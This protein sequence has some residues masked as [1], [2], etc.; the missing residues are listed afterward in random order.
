MTQILV[1]ELWNI[2]DVILAM[3][4]LA[5]LR[6]HFPSSRI[7]LLSR[8]FA[9]ELLAGTGLVDEFLEAKLDW[10]DRNRGNF[11]LRLIRTIRTARVLR[12]RRFDLVFSARGHKRERI[13]LALSGA[14]QRVNLRRVKPNV[15]AQPANA[16][17][18]LNHKVAQ[19]MALLRPF[20]F[21][22]P[23]PSVAL[24]VSDVERAQAL[25]FLKAHG[26]NHSEMVI[27][28]HP[29]ASRPEKRWPLE[30]FKRLASELA[31]LPGVRVIAFAEP[32]PG[33]YGS[34][35]FEIPGVVGVDTTLRGL[36]ALIQSCD[37]LICNDSGPMHIA[38][39][40]GVPTVA[41]F[42]EGISELFGP[43]GSGHHLL[44]PRGGQYFEDG[45]QRHAIR[46]PPGI[47]YDDAWTTVRAALQ[48]VHSQRGSPGATVIAVQ[49]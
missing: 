23:A 2:G 22:G 39:A 4:F 1:I 33:R 20:G 34:E 13:L 26:W 24:A 21:K 38:G 19:W 37:L 10:D 42:G 49:D 6:Q 44:A 36:V 11:V 45:S 25:D 14:R 30:S 16:P 17:A 3:P 48:R 35:L 27:G 43:L 28:I 9:R 29:G 46:S 47:K 32:A 8:G 15:S 7:V 12:R 5:A 31:A 18:A 40:L 41:M